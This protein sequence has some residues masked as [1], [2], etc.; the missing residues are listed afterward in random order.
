MSA[1]GA[2]VVFRTA[3]LRDAPA[4]A[5][6]LDQL[7]YP[8]SPP[9]MRRRLGPILA[10]P[11]YRTLVADK[12]GGVVGFTGACLVPSY[13]LDHAYVRVL[14]LIVDRTVRG[15][16]IGSSLLA[17]VETWA[18]EEGARVV[19]VNARDEDDATAGASSFYAAHG[20]EHT[21]ARYGKVLGAA[22]AHAR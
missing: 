6:L 10:R 11:D 21:G 17:A 5:R 22:G 1:A 3:E 7:G 15:A 14:D 2:P 8:T 16:G 4:I 18:Q 20:Y 12:G 19:V 9:A 13:E